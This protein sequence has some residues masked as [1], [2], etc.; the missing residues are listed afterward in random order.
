MKLRELSLSYPFNVSRVKAIQ[1]LRL[2]LIARNVAILYRDKMVAAN[3]IDPETGFGASNSG[4]GWED[5]Q[6]PGTRSYGIKLNVG[7]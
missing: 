6:L 3:G 4:V 5:F 7:F 2:S 1:S